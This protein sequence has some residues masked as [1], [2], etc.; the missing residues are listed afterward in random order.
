MLLAAKFAA[1]RSPRPSKARP[2]GSFRLRAVN[3][4]GRPEGARAR[5]GELGDAVA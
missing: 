1:N 4:R 3:G 2:N 5:R